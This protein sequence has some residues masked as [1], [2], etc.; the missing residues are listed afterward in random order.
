MIDLSLS[1]RSGRDVAL[2]FLDLD[3]FKTLNDSLGHDI[4]D[5]LLKQV[6]ERLTS[7]IRDSDTAARLGGDE[8]LVML[9]NLSEQ[10]IEAAAQAE[11][12]S[13]KILNEL[14]QP[15]QLDKNEYQSTVSI[16]VAIYGNQNISQDELLK[17]AD[18][19]MYQAKKAGRNSVCF[20][21]PQMQHSIH[22]RL[23]LER[24]LREAIEKKQFKLYY[25]IQ[26]DHLGFPLGAEALI[27]WQ[28]PQRGLVSPFQFIQLAE[29]TGLILPIGQ[30]VLEAA[31]SQ[32]KVWEQDERCRSLTISINVSAKQ[33]RQEGFVN[34]VQTATNRYAINP[35]LLKL[36]LT[37]SILLEG[38]EETIKIMNELKKTGIRFS[39][40][41]FGT[42]YSSLQYLKR[43]PL[44]QLKIDQ[45]FVHDIVSDIND[46]AIV[47]TIIAMAQSMELEVIAE[48]VETIEQ[49]QLLQNTGCMKFQGYLFGKPVSIEEFDFSLNQNMSTSDNVSNY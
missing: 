19:A 13:E 6:A 1:S 35:K 36:E 44:S 31:C 2:L 32:L 48:G 25:Q 23:D 10:P 28:H 18:I 45:S 14:N 42:G 49:R 38:I 5:M 39:L 15:Y 9:E 27:R 37:E 7:C 20:Y 16:G 24:E 30:W 8:Y 41:D 22:A 17:H 34:Q 4:G 26:V 29:E 46:R 11:I 43:L 33:F 12:I 3:H 47:R 40:D 21:D